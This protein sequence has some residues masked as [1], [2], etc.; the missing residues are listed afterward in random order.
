MEKVLNPA[1]LN[2]ALLIPAWDELTVLP[3]GPVFPGEPWE[4]EKSGISPAQSSVPKMPPCCP[5]SC[6]LVSFDSRQALGSWDAWWALLTLWP[7]EIQGMW[8]NE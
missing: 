2:P 8:E 1:L 6:H 5:Q 3:L 4:K 7:L